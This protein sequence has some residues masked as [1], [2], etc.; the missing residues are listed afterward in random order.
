MKYL[1]QKTQV[2]P[3]KTA[4][5]DTQ[6]RIEDTPSERLIV[7]QG[8]SSDVDWKDNFN[9]AIAPY[10][11]MPVKWY[12]H[13]GFVRAW[14]SA[15]KQIMQD[16]L[17]GLDD[18]PVT[19]SAY[20]HGAGIATLLHEDL[21]F[22]SINVTTHTFGGPRCLWLPSKSVQG[23]FTSFYRHVV[24]GDIVT[25]IPPV[26]FLYQHV[27]LERKMGPECFPSHLPHYPEKYFEYLPTMGRS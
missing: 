8:S 18:R 26:I 1:F 22:N 7:L 25:M 19:I 3:W 17:T 14:K 2:G 24:R 13:A 6:Y 21:W 11:D 5:E 9:F 27:G 15:Q 4:G 20:S 23:R 10:R 16:T 12:A